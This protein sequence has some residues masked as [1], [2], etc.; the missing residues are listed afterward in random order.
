MGKNRSCW[1]REGQRQV[2][3]GEIVVGDREGQ[4]LLDEGGIE[5]VDREEQKL[6]EGGI[7]VV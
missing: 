7:E 1:M 6:D 2:D 5:I 4:K 3:E